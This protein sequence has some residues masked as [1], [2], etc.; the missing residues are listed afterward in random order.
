MSIKKEHQNGGH[1]THSPIFRDSFLNRASAHKGKAQRQ[2]PCS[3]VLTVAPGHY[4][5]E[6]RAN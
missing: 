3:C 5:A 6:G 4:Q 1:N 2:A